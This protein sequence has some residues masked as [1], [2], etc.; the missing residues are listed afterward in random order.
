[1]AVKHSLYHEEGQVRVDETRCT[2]C[3]LCVKTCPAEVLSISE[4]AVRQHP[5]GFGCIACGHCMMVCPAECITV[6][7]RN[8][9]HLDLRPLP[10]P[11]ER[12]D[13]D[14]LAAL[15]AARRSVRR[16]ADRPVGAELLERIVAMASAAPMGIPPWDVG[17]TTVAGFEAVRELAGQVVDGYRGVTKVFRP[18]LLKLLKPLLGQA[19]YEQFADFILPLAAMYLETWAAG[20]DTVFWGAP[21]VLLFSHSPYA[22]EPD[23]VIACT[24]AMLAAESLGLGST[25]IG[26][27]PPMLQRNK[28][29]CRDLGIP[30]GHKPALALILGYSAVPFRRG[31]VRRFRHQQEA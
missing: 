26:G 24:Y 21:A 19:R 30:A 3:V 6:S 17:V 1:M 27:A 9:S 15:F 28:R 22:G 13:A 14:A 31:V 8:F 12:A 20:R 23:A 7:G 16:F 5:A 29:L 10:P 18:G 25:M 11:E 2:L 4:G